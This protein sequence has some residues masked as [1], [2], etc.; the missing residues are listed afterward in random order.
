MVAGRHATDRLIEAEHLHALAASLRQG[1]QV[2]IVGRTLGNAASFEVVVGERRRQAAVLANLTTLKARVNDTLTREQ[3]HQLSARDNAGTRNPLERAEGAL[4]TL[5][6]RLATRQHWPSLAG[7][8]PTALHAVHR[9][10]VLV[11]REDQTDAERVC[12]R[13]GMTVAALRT[14]AHEALDLYYG[15]GAPKL[16]TF[17]SGDA[18]LVTYPE[19]LRAKLRLDKLQKSHAQA[20]NSVSDD[21]LREEL[22]HRTVDEGLSVA[23]VRALALEANLNGRLAHEPGLMQL[24]TVLADAQRAIGRSPALSPRSQNKALRLAT[25]LSELLS[26]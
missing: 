5:N 9:L 12:A 3:A 21:A 11:I 10:L 19:P 22:L 13:L 1:Q 6:A 20:I 24:R 18:H 4:R 8:Y 23:A 14:A 7:R 16:S 26:R 25:D 17:S 15:S 2:P